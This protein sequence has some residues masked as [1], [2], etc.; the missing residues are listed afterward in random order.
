MKTK[1]KSI[2][3]NECF[4]RVEMHCWNFASRSNGLFRQDINTAE[5]APSHQMGIIQDR[6]HL[7][8]YVMLTC[9]CAFCYFYLYT[10]LDSI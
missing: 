2:D 5:S 7:D 6:L 10:L 9:L 1:N 8:N 3:V 4:I